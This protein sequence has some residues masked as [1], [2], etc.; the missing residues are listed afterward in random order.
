MDSLNSL[1]D[2]LHCKIHL[3]NQ[4]I[5]CSNFAKWH[6]S[7]HSSRQTR[8]NNRFLFPVHSNLAVPA[9]WGWPLLSYNT[10]SFSQCDRQTYCTL[11]SFLPSIAYE[12]AMI[13]CNIIRPF[14]RHLQ[15][16]QEKYLITHQPAVS[17][18][19]FHSYVHRYADSHARSGRR[20]SK[21]LILSSF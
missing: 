8:D 12:L 13:K 9:A 2:I 7:K 1:D 11:Y 14:Y 6:P 16:H 5:Q 21:I 20:N 4:Q 17:T 19:V 18:D 3:I 15:Q 10:L